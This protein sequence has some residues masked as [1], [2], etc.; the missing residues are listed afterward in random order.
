M[1]GRSLPLLDEIRQRIRWE[2]SAH[3]GRAIAGVAGSGPIHEPPSLCQQEAIASDDYRG[4]M[5][6]EG[7][8]H[9]AKVKENDGGI[10]SYL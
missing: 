2:G 3:A 8:S 6:F 10:A 5:A 4:Q 9:A 7:T 1:T